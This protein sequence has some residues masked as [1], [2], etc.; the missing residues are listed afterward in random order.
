MVMFGMVKTGSNSFAIASGVLLENRYLLML[1]RLLPT[2]REFKRNIQ[3]ISGER[4]C[5]IAPGIQSYHCNICFV[6][7]MSSTIQTVNNRIRQYRH[8][9]KHRSGNFQKHVAHTDHQSKIHN[10]IPNHA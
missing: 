4:R 6:A 5:R 1:P 2:R 8:I 3:R 9:K 7:G 10:N